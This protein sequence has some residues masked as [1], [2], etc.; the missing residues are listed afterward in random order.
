MFVSSLGQPS[1]GSASVG[2]D[3]LLAAPF[4]TGN[5]PGGYELDSVQ[6]AMTPASGSPNGFT[7]MVYSASVFASVLP[8]SSLG[9]LTGSSDPVT[10]GFFTYTAS[11]FM[12]A[13]NTPYF[14]VLNAATSVANGAYAWSFDN[15]PR[16]KVVDGEALIIF[17]VRGMAPRG[18]PTLRIR[19]SL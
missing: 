7:V 13:P 17:S 12:L 18:P 1:T 9:T 3:S 15:S 8:E 11:S 10:G 16:L 14:I 6:L 4:G 5:N 2:S 19:S